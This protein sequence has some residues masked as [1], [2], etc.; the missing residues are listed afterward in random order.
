[1]DAAPFRMPLYLPAQGASETEA[2]IIAWHLAEGDRF[3]KGDRLAEVDSAK[4]VFDF[5]APCDGTVMRLLAAAG[6]TAS[7]TEPVI[8][9]ETADASMRDWIPPA[10][11]VDDPS[12]QRTAPEPADS[13][14]PQPE[15]PATGAVALSALGAYLPARVVANAELV[16]RF[17]AISEDY[18]EQVTGIC[19]RH[20]AAEDEK[21]SDMALAAARDAI[22][23]AGLQPADIGAI[24]LA[25]TTPDV[26]M[27]STACILQSRLGLHHVP[28]FDLNAACSGWLYA[29]SVAEGMIRSGTA[30][31]VLTVGVD[32]Q[33]RLVDPEDQSACFIFGDGAGAAVVSAGGTGR[34]LGRVILGADTRGLELARRGE[35][36]YY[37]HNGRP[38]VDPWIRLEGHGL[39]RLAAQSFAAMIDRALRET[40]WQ[41]D[42]VRWVV[43]HQA[44]GR[45][46]M[47]AAKRC[48]IPRER[49]YL[50]L[51][52]VGNTSSASIPLALVELLPDLQP[53]DRLILCA[54]GAGMTT[55]AVALEW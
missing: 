40:G 48:G 4:S 45:I 32:L 28:A 9:I 49:F 14:R 31:H 10:A 11:G 34:R 6:D 47:A 2:T 23:N 17:P 29:V 55:A 12:F 33:S 20:W 5:E 8:E 35:P 26:A 53:G 51:E 50:N 25:T 21:P 27:P 13:P 37:V 1:M 41:A 24:V 22:R 15:M 39:F 30:R 54:V 42:Q 43:P 19:R 46:L 7:Y 3:H 18:V 44:N 38:H 36:G 52:R 16:R